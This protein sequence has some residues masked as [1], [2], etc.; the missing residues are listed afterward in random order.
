M[1]GTL[2]PLLVRYVKENSEEFRVLLRE[3]HSQ[4]AAAK[5]LYDDNGTHGNE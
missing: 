3:I 2:S 5:E 4:M 1:K